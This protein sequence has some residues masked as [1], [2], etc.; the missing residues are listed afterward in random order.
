MKLLK[1]RVLSITL[2]VIASFVYLL[3]L[4]PSLNTVNILSVK[5]LVII[6]SFLS[7]LVLFYFYYLFNKMF[8]KLILFKK[9][10]EKKIFLNALLMTFLGYITFLWFNT[11]VNFSFFTALI[12]VILNSLWLFI[13]IY[14]FEEKSPSKIF[15]FSALNIVFAIIGY[16]SML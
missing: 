5:Y 10:H 16:I 2:F 12:I 13:Y 11:L 15:F 8:L 4:V 9:I 6:M 14:F 1:S 7:F 3:L